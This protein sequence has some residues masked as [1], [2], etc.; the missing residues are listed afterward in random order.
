MDDIGVMVNGKFG[1]CGNCDEDNET[2]PK[3]TT[4]EM[5]DQGPGDIKETKRSDWLRDQYYKTILTVIELL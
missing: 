2:A 1:I 5:P 4:G 3:M